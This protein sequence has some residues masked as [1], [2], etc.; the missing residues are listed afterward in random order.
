MGKKRK[1]KQQ[2]IK[3]KKK[4]SVWAEEAPKKGGKTVGGKGEP[5][6]EVVQATEVPS[7]VLSPRNS[8]EQEE[9]I[10]CTPLTR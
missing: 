3:K 4:T 10:I 1:I 9:H 2:N 7:P 5:G 6:D 8:E